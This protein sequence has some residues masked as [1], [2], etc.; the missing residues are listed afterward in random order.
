M[1]LTQTYTL[2]TRAYLAVTS[3]SVIVCRSLPF[4]AS[5]RAAVNQASICAVGKP[6]KSGLHMHVTRQGKVP[7]RPSQA[8][9]AACG[10]DRPLPGILE[11]PPGHNSG[12]TKAWNGRH[13]VGRAVMCAESL[14]GVGRES[15]V[16]ASKWCWRK[17]CGN[18][19]LPLAAS[20]PLLPLAVAMCGSD[21][22]IVQR[23][24]ERSVS[25]YLR[26]E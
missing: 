15:G 20:S 12:R 26:H 19:C 6:G 7:A 24:N 23:P 1:T 5:I 17:E 13:G 9:C 25:D 8:E 10:V 11:D 22:R 18:R 21:E 14:E 3:V 2:I 4:Q 16:V